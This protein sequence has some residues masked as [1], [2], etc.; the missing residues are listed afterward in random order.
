MMQ[1]LGGT[2]G[3]GE[4]DINTFADQALDDSVRSLFISLPISAWGTWR[5]RWTVSYGFGLRKKEVRP[6]NDEAK[7]QARIPDAEKAGLTRRGDAEKN[8]AKT[9]RGTGRLA[10][11]A[12]E[13]E[14][15][16]PRNSS[17]CSFAECSND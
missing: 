13:A 14:E 8:S 5:A 9:R 17:G 3:V 2:A 4:D 7:R 6:C 11:E 15:V 10:T 16:E 1:L 12:Q